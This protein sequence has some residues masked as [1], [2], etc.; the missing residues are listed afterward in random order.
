MIQS[1]GVED[2]RYRLSSAF[3]M[4]S[5]RNRALLVY[6]SADMLANTLA[7]DRQKI[8]SDKEIDLVHV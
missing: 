7:L 5:M 1:V 2:A 4:T 8:E 6:K 3:C